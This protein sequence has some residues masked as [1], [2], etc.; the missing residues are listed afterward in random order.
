MTSNDY[1]IL[2]VR[3]ATVLVDH[4]HINRQMYKGSPKN[5]ASLQYTTDQRLMQKVLQ[6]HI[7]LQKTYSQTSRVTEED[8]DAFNS[9]RSLTDQKESK[10]KD[11]LSVEESIK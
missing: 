8:I 1:S 5:R 6:P 4:P 11:L 10:P 2:K 9:E 3:G 7:S